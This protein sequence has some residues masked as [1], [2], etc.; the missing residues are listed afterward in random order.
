VVRGGFIVRVFQVVTTDIACCTALMSTSSFSFT[1]KNSFPRHAAA[2]IN[3]GS[4]WQWILNPEP[5]NSGLY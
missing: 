2:T 3:V 1:V 5:I 4:H